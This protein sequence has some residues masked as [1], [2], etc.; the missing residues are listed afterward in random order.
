MTIKTRV[1]R[2]ITRTQFAALET[3]Y[4]AKFNL[5]E[6]KASKKAAEYEAMI[7]ASQAKL[8]E[9]KLVPGYTTI[10]N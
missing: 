4:T 9:T 10:Y 3:Y 1:Y 2:T 8:A 7:A 5:A 6:K